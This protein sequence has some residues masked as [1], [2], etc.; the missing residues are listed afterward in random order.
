MEPGNIRQIVHL[1]GNVEPRTEVGV[2][3]ET[4]GRIT[5]LL[6]AVGDPVKTG[7][8]IA[9]ID[10]SRPGVSFSQNP[11]TSPV[12]GTV[13]TLPLSVGATVPSTSTLLATIG[14]ISS[15]KITIYVAE[16]Y[17]AY[18]R[19]GLPA[20]ASFAAAPGEQFPASVVTISPVVNTSNRTIETELALDNLDPRIKPGMLAEVDLVIR[21]RTA[22]FVLPRG[23]IK[24]YN[25][26]QVVYIIDGNDIARRVTVT[27]GLS[28]DTEIEVLTGLSRGDRVIVAGAVTDGSPVR[29]AGA[30]STAAPASG[31]AGDR[32][33]AGGAAPAGGSTAPAAGGAGDR[34]SAGGAGSAGDG[35]PTGSGGGRTRGG[36]GAGGCG[37]SGGGRPPS[38]APSSGSGTPPSG[39][40]AP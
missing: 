4:T 39:A 26:D 18:L 21:E 22:A 6:K 17:S 30:T 36:Q 27:T 29:V 8:I 23:A 34:A 13:I 35:A 3:P 2:Y 7:D 19:K 33:S 15:L 20:L 10:P 16:K 5:R 11:V 32:A 31:S 37:G 28:N 14:S 12:S 40:G 1:N 38:G 25:D 9:Y 24:N